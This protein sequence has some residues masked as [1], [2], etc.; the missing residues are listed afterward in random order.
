MYRNMN[1]WAR[2]KRIGKGKDPIRKKIIDDDLMLQIFL[3]M[4][5]NFLL[6]NYTEGN[7]FCLWKQINFTT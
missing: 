3:S 1:E 4:K 2:K 7:K 6:S 5:F